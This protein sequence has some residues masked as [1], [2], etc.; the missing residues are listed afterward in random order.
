[1][2][3]RV[4]RP[5]FEPESTQESARNESAD[6]Y[7][8]ELAKTFLKLQTFFD[9]HARDILDESDDV[10]RPKFQLI[11]AIGD[12]HP[13][14]GSPDRWLVIQQVLELLKHADSPT[15][16]RCDDRSPGSFP[17]IQVKDNERLVSLLVEGVLCL[18]TLRLHSELKLKEFTREFIVHKDPPT[19]TVKMMEEFAR[20]STS[21]GSLLL[22]RGLFAHNILLFALTQ[23]RW[24]VDYGL[25]TNPQPRTMLA[26]PYRAKDVPAEAAEFSHPDMTIILT[27]L[28]YYYRGLTEEE[29][30]TSFELLLQEDDPDSE[31]ARWLKGYNAGLVPD[32]LQK[33][34]GVN[35]RSSEQWGRYLYRL[36]T[37][38]KRAIDLYLSK[39]VFPKYAEEFLQKI[40]GSYW[41]IA[42]EKD[43]PV[44]GWWPCKFC[45]ACRLN[46]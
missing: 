37:R 36:F 6:M 27:C 1:M 42:E 35:I 20:Q 33:L 28:C 18:P 23:R 7:E 32:A 26:I 12:R 17:Y 40:L 16:I 25:D 13:F 43:Y 5:H 8:T 4:R 45:Q 34:S 44:T 24:R 29:L 19:E 22:L 38:N 15:I 30:R 46:L 39:I 2:I 41:D 9:T 10:L 3:D 11:Y 14:E 31:Y 21:W